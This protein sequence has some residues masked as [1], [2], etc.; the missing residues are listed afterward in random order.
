MTEQSEVILPMQAYKV[1][2]VSCTPG[3]SKAGAKQFT[4]EFEVI[5][6]APVNGV[7][8]NGVKIQNW[9]T[10]V[11]SGLFFVNEQRIAMGLSK[12][13]LAQFDSVTP[14][15]YLGQIAY[16]VAHSDSK[17]MI[18]EVTKQPILHP[19]TGKVVINWNRKISK[20]LAPG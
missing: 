9:H 13:T 18:N 20:W 6:A 8:I 12:L 10:F 4:Q 7:D 5:E 11:E 19:L 1:R 17:P 14:T 16:V 15:E 3:V 2:C